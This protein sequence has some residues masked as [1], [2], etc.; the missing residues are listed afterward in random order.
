MSFTERTV[1]DVIFAW[2]GLLITELVPVQSLLYYSQTLLPFQGLSNGVENDQN[3]ANQIPPS[4]LPAK[5]L[6]TSSTTSNQSYDSNVDYA[7]PK[8][9][10]NHVNSH[11]T[12]DPEPTENGYAKNTNPLFGVN[13]AS[14]YAP[15]QNHDDKHYEAMPNGVRKAPEGQDNDAFKPEDDVDGRKDNI[16]NTNQI[17]LAETGTTTYT[18]NNGKINVHVT[19]MINAGNYMHPYIPPTPVVSAHV[20]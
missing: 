10:Y 3:T 7:V 18:D 8:H 2:S 19:V 1:V 13:A 4:E 12:D 9:T 6:S 5:R 16:A 14:H 20:V 17:A 15:G 11:R